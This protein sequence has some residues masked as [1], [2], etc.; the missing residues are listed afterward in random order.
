MDK[1]RDVVELYLAP[2]EHAPP[3]GSSNASPEVLKESMTQ[4]AGAAPSLS[5]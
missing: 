5:D 2:S 1:V 3:T 4:D